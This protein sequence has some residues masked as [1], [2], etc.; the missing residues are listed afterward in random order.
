MR[1]GN[2]GWH[3]YLRFWRADP[4][5]E[6]E[7]E[8]AFH[9]QA[10]V[11]EYVTAGLDPA[12]ARAE[13]VKR[14]GDL[15][16]VRTACLRIDKQYAR[17]RSMSDVVSGIRGDVR[18]ALRQLRRQHTLTLTAVLCLT[19]GIGVNTAI[20]S[21]VDAVLF[22]PLPFRDPGRLVLVGEGLPMIS[23]Q[24]FGQ[25]STPDYLDFGTLDGSVFESSAAFQATSLTISGR[26]AP[27]Q[28]D[29]LEVS[30]SL[31]DVLGVHAALGRGFQRGDDAVGGPGVVV[32][33]DAFWRRR[34]GADPSI[35]GRP[36][37][38]DGRPVTVIGVL[39]PSFSFPLP[40]LG[41]DPA[42]L[43]VP[44]RMTP[45]VMQMRGNAYNAYMIARLAPGVPIGRAAEA[46]NTIA[47]R[48]PATY[49]A[50]YPASAR[51]VA[52]AMPLR[53]R[54]VS[55]IRR[56][57]LILLGA[58]GFVLLIACIN[59][60]GLLLARA[61]ARSR[62]L[63]VRRALGASRGRLV[64]QHLAES[65]VLVACGAAGALVAA[66]WSTKALA[67]L[68]PGDLLAGYHIG[69]DARVLAFTL[70]V[71]VVVA[72]VFSF[73]P[74]LGRS[75]RSIP[76]ELR[77]EGR[78]TSTG[79][80]RQRGRRV[81]VVSE[82]ALAL[83][84]ATGAGLLVRSFVNALRVDPG[85][86]PDRLL[87]F[88]VAFPR[89]RYPTAARALDAER[90]TADALARMP[91]ARSASAAVN[92]PFVGLW[93]ITFTPEGVTLPSVP[94]AANFIVMPGYFE[95]MGIRLIEGRTFDARDA[96]ESPRVAIIDERLA[97]QFFANVSPIGQRLKWG[98]PQSTDPW[99]T[100]IGVVRTVKTRSLDEETV[101][102]IYFPALQLAQDTSFANLA[103]RGLSYIVRTRG[104]PVAMAAQA[105]RVLG[106]VDPEL[107]MTRIESGASLIRQAMAGR[108]FDLLLIGTFAGLALA[109]AAVGVYGLVAYSVVQRRREIGVRLAVGATTRGV[110]GLV[111]REGA[112]TAAAGAALGLAGAMALT[113]LMRSL[114]FGV[115][116][117]DATTFAA[118]TGL[119]IA[120]ALAASWM[121]ARLAARVDP[122][123]ALRGE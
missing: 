98:T 84:L 92:L 60:A 116:A 52:D 20:F 90:Q 11:D 56:P 106:Q 40:G 107:P 41:V 33:T 17:R 79:R 73:V 104:D 10:R 13:A 44:L 77:E 61:A 43:F 122:V 115:G 89:Y 59:V 16:R 87:S 67:A 25:I 2:P 78:G 9:L 88:Q 15:T 50:V 47:A 99:A 5:A 96:G 64:Q 48:M 28:V 81:L 4:R 31:L 36:I 22:R 39:P 32:I 35:V 49:P 114:L 120:V 75:E 94:T 23:D 93:Q 108:R 113:R 58:V 30:A 45:D 101:P 42:A 62:E 63:A 57:L 74:A 91:G 71:A 53:T 12:Q 68:A 66:H 34:F 83:V 7:D 82:I 8:L 111:L 54:L 119:L 24:N 69:L 29:G 46:V 86:R 70:G 1:Q 105:R 3:R 118:A 103:L 55:G 85:F 97:R 18:L 95:T 65:V 72:L 102:E 100:I 51:I 6:L 21:V 112:A 117:L 121:P 109:L 37:V 38:L 26:S 80:G 27:E 123:T 14:L 19:L 76:A 110:V